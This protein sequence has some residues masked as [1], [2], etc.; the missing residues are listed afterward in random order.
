MVAKAGS[1]NIDVYLT[2]KGAEYHRGPGGGQEYKCPWPV[3][4]GTGYASNRLT[5]RLPC[6]KRCLTSARAGCRNAN[7]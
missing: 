7:I 2:A 1:R 6:S 3:R 5:G 4:L